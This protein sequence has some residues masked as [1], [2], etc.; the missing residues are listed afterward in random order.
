M[1]SVS[2][3]RAFH[4]SKYSKKKKDMHTGSCV[5]EERPSE[6]RTRK[7]LSD[8]LKEYTDLGIVLCGS[9]YFE[10]RIGTSQTRVA[11]KAIDVEF[12]RPVA[13]TL[14]FDGNKV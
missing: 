2:D 11:V 12:L 13:R 9:R 10:P 4:F 1:H 7:F 6:Q 5:P 3:H 14:F 8:D